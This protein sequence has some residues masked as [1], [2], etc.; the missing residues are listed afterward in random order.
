MKNLLISTIITH[1]FFDILNESNNKLSVSMKLLYKYLKNLGFFYLIS[2]VF[3]VSITLL[4]VLSS[5][6]HFNYDFIP[7]Q[8]KFLN[9]NL[10]YK[11]MGSLVIL[12]TFMHNQSLKFWEDS[13]L[14]LNI[15][16]YYVNFIILTIFGVVFIYFI[17]LFYEEIIKD[18]KIHLGKIFIVSLL[19]INGY[20]NNPYYC[21]VNYLGFFHTPIAIYF[22]SQKPLIV[23]GRKYQIWLIWI[24]LSILVFI[25]LEIHNDYI[26]GLANNSNFLKLIIS[27]LLTHTVFDYQKR[28]KKDTE[29]KNEILKLINN[30]KSKKKVNKI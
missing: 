1:G 30:I 4:F 23:L 7:I 29:L 10:D 19:L 24:I 21:M 15:D 12:S 26:L 13:L 20:I 17:T 6:H 27:I 28:L 16:I 22:L 18:N 2:Q 3:P 5:I 25:F 14:K 11:N 8:N 9:L